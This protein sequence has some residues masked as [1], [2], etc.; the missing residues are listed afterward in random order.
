MHELASMAAS[1]AQDMTYLP[2]PPPELVSGPN[3]TNDAHDKVRQ[4]SYKFSGSFFGVCFLCLIETNGIL[5]FFKNLGGWSGA[6]W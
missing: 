6:R 2:P 3:A 1:K 5:L 4:T